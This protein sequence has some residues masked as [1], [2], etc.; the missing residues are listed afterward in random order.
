MRTQGLAQMD[1]KDTRSPTSL[2]V[3]HP[4][5][6]HIEQ[7]EHELLRMMPNFMRQ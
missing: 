6:V 1:G 5:P 4:L 7:K 3:P 2:V